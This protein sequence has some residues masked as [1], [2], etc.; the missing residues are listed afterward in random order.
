MRKF[1]SVFLTFILLTVGLGGCST[2]N[3]APV[4]TGEDDFGSEGTTFVPVRVVYPSGSASK[5]TNGITSFASRFSDLGLGTLTVT[6]DSETPDDGACEI[7]VGETNRSASVDM[8]GSYIHSADFSGHYYAVLRKDN[9]VCV[10]GTDVDALLIGLKNLLDPEFSYTPADSDSNILCQKGYDDD[11]VVFENLVV[12]E[13]ESVSLI[14]EPPASLPN[15]VLKYP[16]FIE[17]TYQEDASKNGILLMT[18]EDDTRASAQI[19]RSTDG[20]ATW[21]ISAKIPDPL[22]S[23]FRSF[24]APCL[25]ELPVSVGEMPRGTIILGTN[26]VN[27]DWSV[28]YIMLYRSYDQGETWEYFTTV[29]ESFRTTEFGVWEPNFVCTDEGRL[30]CYY[31]DD[32]D[33][34]CSQK[35]VLKYTDDGVNWSEPIDTVALSNGSLRPGMPVV[36]RMGDGR[37][38]MVYEI[39]GLT[40]NPVYYKISEDPIDWGNAM[41]TGTLIRSGSRKTLAATPWVE[42]APVGGEQGMLVVTGWR[43]ASGTS[44]TGSDIFVSFNCGKTWTTIDN[45]YSYTW[46]SDNDIW[47]YSV[48]TFF[49]SDG[50]TM[51]YCV[52]PKGEGNIRS[53]FMLYKIKVS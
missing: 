2:E 6:D 10:V 44:N 18:G 30:I 39:V 5:L 19:H 34:I 16:T 7:L 29:A 15:A 45:Y 25:F 36:K 1:W 3:D 43:M 22:H 46:A 32:D 26:S 52:N 8:Y 11:P 17:L 51:Y 41:D 48:C 35:L 4:T 31:S 20:G 21:D 9:S 23:G 53:C 14:H 37:Y 50:E 49:S 40:N 42:W 13:L 33:K 12:W 47:G 27:L 28:T 38:I 24:Y